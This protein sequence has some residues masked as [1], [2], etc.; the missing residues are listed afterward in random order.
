M[1]YY[2]VLFIGL[3]FAWHPF[4]YFGGAAIVY[5]SLTDFIVKRPGLFYPVFLCFYLLEHLA[6]QTG[7][8][9]GCVKN[10]YFGAYLVSFKRI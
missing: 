8:F 2:L 3:G 7:V 6:Y 10:G 9:W 4:W 5:T 1:R